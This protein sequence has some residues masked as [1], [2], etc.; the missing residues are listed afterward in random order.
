MP[1]ENERRSSRD[2]L[3]STMALAASSRRGND[4]RNRHLVLARRADCGLVSGAVE[5]RRRCRRHARPGGHQG[6]L[7]LLR[8]RDRRPRRAGRHPDQDLDGSAHVEERRIRSARSAGM[9]HARDPSGAQRMGAR[10]LVLQ[11]QVPPVLL[12]VVILGAATPLSDW[13]R[14]PR[15][16]PRALDTR[17]RTRGWRCGPSSRRTIGTPST[18]TW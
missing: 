5:A 8:V 7:D 6:R 15:S 12:G 10:H 4:R 13:S 16:I 9:G 18:R 2:R 11:R 3:C 14:R 1:R 17:G